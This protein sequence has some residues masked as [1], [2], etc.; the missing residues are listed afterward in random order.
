MT[1]SDGRY[2]FPLEV[3]HYND[4][5][6]EAGYDSPIYLVV[7]Q[8]PNGED[9]WLSCSPEQLV[10]R[11]CLRWVSLRNAPAPERDD[12]ESITVYLPESQVLTPNAL[13]ELARM[14]SLE[15]WINYN[16]EGIAHADHA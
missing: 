2:S 13:R 11:R 9:E 1:H 10:L 16:V 6:L 12:Q 14:R 7:F 8:M 5:R 4:F 3:K 15:Q